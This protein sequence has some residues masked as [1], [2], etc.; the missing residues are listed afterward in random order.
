[1]NGWWLYFSKLAG[2][3]ISA[4]ALVIRGVCLLFMTWILT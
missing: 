2:V 1:M 3:P 4:G